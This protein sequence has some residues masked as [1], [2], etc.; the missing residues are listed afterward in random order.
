MKRAGDKALHQLIMCDLK[1]GLMPSITAAAELLTR[2]WTSQDCM[3]F[4]PVQV[5]ITMVNICP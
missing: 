5:F 1:D 4:M 3:F 2:M